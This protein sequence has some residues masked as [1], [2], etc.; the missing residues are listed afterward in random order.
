MDD[1]QRVLFE[2]WISGEPYTRSVERWPVRA[3]V[4]WPGQ[5]RDYTVQLAWEA[6]QQALIAHQKG[7]HGGEQQHLWDD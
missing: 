2:G 3:R 5:Y 7:E 6:W 1:T 4:A